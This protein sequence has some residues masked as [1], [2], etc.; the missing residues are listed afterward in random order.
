[1]QT[2]FREGDPRTLTCL[3]HEVLVVTTAKPHVAT[4]K[5]LNLSLG[6]RE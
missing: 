4:G 5:M 2:D 3:V 1:M 6:H